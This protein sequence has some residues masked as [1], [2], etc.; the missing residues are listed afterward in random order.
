VEVCRRSGAGK[1]VFVVINFAQESRRVN[2]PRAM[3]LLLADKQG[4]TL[5]LPAYGVEVLAENP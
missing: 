2:L 1:Q 4:D 5:E 3:K